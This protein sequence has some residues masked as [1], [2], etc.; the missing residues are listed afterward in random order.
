MFIFTPADLGAVIRDRRKHLKL[1]QATLATKIGVS[2]QWVIDIERGHPRRRIPRSKKSSY[3]A[4]QV[5]AAIEG[6][7]AGLT[8]SQL[9]SYRH[10]DTRVIRANQLQAPMCDDPQLAALLKPIFLKKR[11]SL[12]QPRK[13]IVAK[14][15]NR[16]PSLTGIIAGPSNEIFTA[17]DRAGPRYLDFETRKE[18]MSE[19]MLAIL[20]GALTIEDAPRRYREFL[21]ATHRMFPTKYGRAMLKRHSIWRRT[22]RTRTMPMGWPSWRKSGSFARCA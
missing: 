20:E 16:G 11:A 21:R 9:T 1:D 8:M 10:S 12:Y 14:S 4:E 2:R 22:R 3:T 13:L 15:I 17:V 6:A 18:V 19:M 7:K 5:N